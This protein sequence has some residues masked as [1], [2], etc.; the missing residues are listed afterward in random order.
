MSKR[1][2][3][4]QTCMVCH[5][6][7]V[8]AGTFGH[9]PAFSSS[10]GRL[11]L[12]KMWDIFPH[13]FFFMMVL[14]FLYA[15]IIFPRDQKWLK[16]ILSKWQK[17]ARQDHDVPDNVSGWSNYGFRSLARV[18]L[19]LSPRRSTQRQAVSFGDVSS[20]YSDPDFSESSRNLNLQG[21]KKC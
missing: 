12:R 18:R 20:A 21:W 17:S 19:V 3:L 10:G 5:V 8:S 16:V 13:I 4:L 15:F 11:V 14:S 2:K 9:R 1:G 7:T 6:H